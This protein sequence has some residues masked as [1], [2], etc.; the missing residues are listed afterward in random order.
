MDNGVKKNSL[1]DL[2][3]KETLKNKL[4]IRL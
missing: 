4:G 1:T 2:E 3:C